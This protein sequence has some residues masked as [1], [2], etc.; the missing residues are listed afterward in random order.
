MDTT[1]TSLFVPAQDSLYFDFVF[2]I[3]DSI[4]YHNDIDTLFYSY[5]LSYNDDDSLDNQVENFVIVSD[6]TV[7]LTHNFVIHDTHDYIYSPSVSPIEF[8]RFVFQKLPEWDQ[9]SLNL[10]LF[11]LITLQEHQLEGYLMQLTQ[12]FSFNQSFCNLCSPELIIDY[13]LNYNYV[14]IDPHWNFSRSVISPNGRMDIILRSIHSYYSYF[15]CSTDM[16]HDMRVKADSTF[17]FFY[18]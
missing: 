9:L 13:G 15:G 2:A 18:F 7:S 5:A 1:F 11:Q 14:H 17:Q 6:N 4:K 12:D 8:Q 16:Y 10:Y 3:P